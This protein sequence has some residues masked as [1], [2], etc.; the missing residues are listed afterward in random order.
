MHQKSNIGMTMIDHDPFA[1]FNYH[2]K[3]VKMIVW[4]D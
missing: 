1:M 2:A 3:D 4:S